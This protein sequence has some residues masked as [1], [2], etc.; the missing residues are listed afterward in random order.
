M[1]NPPINPELLTNLS[2]QQIE[3]MSQITFAQLHEHA[4]KIGAVSILGMFDALK[5][6]KPK[7]SWASW[8]AFIAA[9]FA[10]PMS[11]A[12]RKVYAACTGRTELPEAPAREADVIVGRRGGKDRI[13]SF[14][15]V[16]LA[17]CRDYSPYLADGQRGYLPVIAADRK[18]S[19][20]IMSYLKGLYAL[21]QFAHL[22]ES[23]TG[24]QIRLTNR[25]TIEIFTS[26]YRTARGYTLVGAICNEI[27]FWRN[28]ESKNPD[29]EIMKA[30]R[31]GMAT[32]PGA[33]LIRLSS[34]YARKGV[35][36][37]Q[38]ERHYGK[39]GDNLVWKAP[40]LLMHPG[41]PQV[42]AEVERAYRDDPVSADAEY[43]GEFRKDLEAFVTR[44]LI[45]AVTVKGR[46]ELPPR[47]DREYDAFVDVSGGSV[48]SFTLSIGHFDKKTGKAIQDVF[49][50]WPAPFDPEVVVGECV[51]DVKRYGVRFVKGDKYAGEWPR[52]MF[53]QHG[54]G[55]VPSDDTKNDLY[56]DFLPLVNAQLVELLD[57]PE[58]AKQLI[59][60]ERRT[61][62]GGRQTIDHPPG[63]H[64]DAAN[65]TAGGMVLT[66]RHHKSPELKE[67]MP[68]SLTEMRARE[69]AKK[70]AEYTKPADETVPTR[71]NILNG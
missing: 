14:L 2:P 20:E 63:E 35:L 51:S 46:Y 22:V 4:V 5:P 23:Q 15:A 68:T 12:E 56:R 57:I 18:Q 48:D 67:P 69:L 28:E 6:F 9:L 47:Q 1:Q 42:E 25:V 61:T 33:L 10:L 32:I 24:E 13:S 41:N 70:M 16:I 27:A 7:A 71:Y 3:D 30:I 59:R 8:R 58:I 66:H 40:T 49:R 52:A 43:G 17:S 21:P 19:R 54:V 50:E 11:E 39:P 55:Y 37:A 62:R 38:Y 31:P 29:E 60:L 65:V 64:D 36:F 44:E 26:S 53:R 34:P 45:E